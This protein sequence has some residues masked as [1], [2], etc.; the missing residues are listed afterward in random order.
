MHQD[1]RDDDGAEKGGDQ[2]RH[3]QEALSQ[4]VTDE[5]MQVKVLTAEATLQSK[6]MNDI[7]DAEDLRATFKQQCDVD[8]SSASFHLH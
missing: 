3:L 5:K 4:K 7:T 2:L 1:R 6:N 8:V